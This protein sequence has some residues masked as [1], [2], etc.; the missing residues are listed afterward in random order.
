MPAWLALE[1]GS[2]RL[3]IAAHRRWGKDE[4]MLHWAATSAFSR[5]GP[6]WHL[7][8]QANQARKALWDAVNPRTGRR[9]IDDAFPAELRASTREQDMF[10]RFVNGS[11][12]QVI[13]SDNYDALVGSPPVGVTFSEY[14]LSNPASWSFIRPILAENG[15]WAAFISTVRGRNHFWRL[16]EYALK[17]PDWYGQVITADD[18]RAIPKEVIHRERRELT[19]ERGPVEAN[20]IIQQEYYC[21]PDAALPGA[22]YG[23]LMTRAQIE[24]RIE[25][26][27]WL[28]TLPVGIACD[29]GHG[30]QT[31]CWFY[32]QLPSGRIRLIDVLVGSGVGIDWYA[33]RITARPYLVT[34][35][36]WPHD[37]DHGNIRDSNGTT[38]MG[39]AQG[40]GWRP[41]RCLDRDQSVD[42]GIQA[43]RQIFP[44]LEVNEHPLPFEDETQDDANARMARALDA[45]RGYRREWDEARQRFKDAPLHDWTS[46]YAD[47]LRYLARGRKRLDR[48]N[49]N[50][51]R[52]AV[53]QDSYAIL[54]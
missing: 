25:D 14:A 21:D 38:L 23:E 16:V 8:P 10:I 31:V 53:G 20:A 52:P 35:T 45:L 27:P 4:I 42:V 5:V 3:A 7:L 50:P 2:T 36:I 6:Y 47:A 12:W 39:Q 33:R 32:Q 22:Y 49:Q 46:D 40:F 34:D 13:G 44:M 41:I 43:V 15:G 26:Y 24:G 19:A 17:D 28:S 48:P 37:G 51:R 18:S 30:D 1:G 11:T 29:L 54:G 9:R